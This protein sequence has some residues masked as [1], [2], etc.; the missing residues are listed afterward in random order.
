MRTKY[1]PSRKSFKPSR[2]IIGFAFL[3]VLS[4]LFSFIP[5]LKDGLINT[6]SN[7]AWFVRNFTLTTF[8]KVLYP[9]NEVSTGSFS[10]TTQNAEI[11]ILEKENAS[12]KS[13]LGRKPANRSVLARV[14]V[15]PPQAPYD[16]IVVDVG[17]EEG[18]L[19]GAQIFDDNGSLIG[20]VQS[21]SAHFSKAQLF[22]SPSAG[23]EAELLR[24]G[25]VLSLSGLGDG[26]FT[27][28]VPRDFDIR[29]GDVFVL[30]GLKS[31]PLASVEQIKSDPE[32]SF[33][34]VYLKGFFEPR[35][36]TWVLIESRN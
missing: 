13:I 29:E 3:V 35:T 20:T 27:V 23:T 12:L 31:R 7:S 25:S 14:L 19:S 9:W 32:N 33:K 18:I 34:M 11:Q 5:L 28:E 24:V 21:V 15:K 36:L 22:S 10:S 2:E 6:Y 17:S 1:H 4:I 30:P 26:S 8:E 16:E